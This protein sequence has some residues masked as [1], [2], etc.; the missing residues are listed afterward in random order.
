MPV[1]PAPV[2]RRRLPARLPVRMSAHGGAGG[3]SPGV[4]EVLLANRD[5]FLGFL[6]RRVRR[7]DVAEEILQEA[8]VRGL[9][10]GRTLRRD[11]S[12]VAWFYR[13]LRNAIIDRQRGES[14]E[15]RGLGALGR[16]SA[17]RED[18]EPDQELVDMVCTCVRSLVGTLKPE[19]ATA[20][21]R[22]E[23][24]DEALPEYAAAAGITRG[25]AAVRLHR[26]RQALRRRVEQ[27]CGAC[28]T[29]GCRDCRCGEG[30]TAGA[31]PVA[32]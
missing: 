19:Y 22:V 7:R 11:E 10:R 21:E 30:P 5:R 14:A 29:N 27:T 2:R 8:F 17:A 9:A 1:L 4:L 31:A 6:E 16:E 18:A 24:G 3:L 26:A 13:S 25:N 20:I 32:P 12:A 23:L 15:Q 28:A